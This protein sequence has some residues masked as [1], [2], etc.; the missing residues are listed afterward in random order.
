MSINMEGYD[1]SYRGTFYNPIKIKLTFRQPKGMFEKIPQIE[2]IRLIYINK[3]GILE[4][5]EDE[6]WMFKFVKR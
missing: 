5:I 1:V 2:F 6:V 3:N 4:S